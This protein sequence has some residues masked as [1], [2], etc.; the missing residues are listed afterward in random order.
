M[1]NDD[2]E[3][4]VD[5]SLLARVYGEYVE[6]PGIQLTLAQASRLWSAGPVDCAHALETL[7]EASFLRRAGDC[8]VRVDSG[9]LCA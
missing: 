7:V 3:R 5:V 8:Y 9:R 6:M 4:D 1:D 2:D